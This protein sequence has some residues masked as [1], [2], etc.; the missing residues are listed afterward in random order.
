MSLNCPRLALLSLLTALALSPAA[1]AAE[2]SFSDVSSDAWYVGSV[3]YVQ[4]Q[5]L[6]SG[7]TE[8]LFSPDLSMSRAMLATT[9][10]RMAGSPEVSGSDTFTDTQDGAWYAGAV[11]W[12]QQ[13]S[14]ISGYDLH[15]FG[16]DDPVTREQLVTILW[17]YAGSP[18]ADVS[19]SFTDEEEL[20]SWAV[21][22]VHWAASGGLITGRPG[23]LFDPS[24]QTT[25]A[26]TAA[27]LTRYLQQSPGAGEVPEEAAPET[28]APVSETPD[29]DV[30]V[31]EIPAETPPAGTETPEV[32]GPPEGIPI[33]ELPFVPPEEAPPSEEDVPGDGTVEAPL[34]PEAEEAI[35]LNQ[36]D[37]SLFAV[38][39]GF[40]TYRGGTPCYVGVD[41]S[42]HQ[43]EIDWQRVAGAGVEFAMIRVGYR[44]YTA[45]SIY[46]DNFFTANITGAL[47]AGLDV[48]IY[49]YSQAV[50]TEEAAEEARQVLEWIKDYEIT[51]PV[52]F[53]WERMKTSSSRTKD[54]TGATITTC[55]QV[56]CD[57]IQ[58][59]GYT[60]MVYCNTSDAGT[61]F[62][63]SQLQ[64][65]PFWLAHYTPDWTPTTFPYHYDMWQYS[66]NGSVD[67]IPGRVDLNLCLADWQR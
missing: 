12:A 22:G 32:S 42:S 6:M 27:I 17:R 8:T 44:G 20:S 55:A 28:D 52:V 7:T 65:Y 21:Q 34:P 2:S 58:D 46:Q 33:P 23:N 66:S 62:Y 4:E 40:L 54:T 25:R 5:G 41:V 1:Q 9:L 61:D 39:N 57:I 37:S 3:A 31:E 51:Y 26:E 38:E 56:F 64:D 36:Y 24:A 14:Y 13:G 43:G 47:D 67:G 59:A 48:G 19:A 15:T 45:G 50:N 35:P 63:L 11:L 53:D 60:A 16:P 49:F 30:S 10:Y 29:S 18:Q